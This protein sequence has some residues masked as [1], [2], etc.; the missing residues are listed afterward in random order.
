MEFTLN[1]PT[2]GGTEI[3]PVVKDGEVLFILGANGTGKSSLMHRFFT[4]HKEQ[5]HRIAAHRRNWFSSN[6]VEVSSKQRQELGTNLRNQDMA[7]DSRWKDD[8]GE[9]RTSFAL[10][11]LINS[12]NARARNIAAAVDGK[13][14]LLAEERSAKAAPI[15]DINELLRLSNIHIELTIEE[16]DRVVARK[17]GGNEYSISELSDGER[18]ALL[19]AAS[20]LT[21]APSTLILIDEPERHLHRSIVSP[22]LSLLVAKRAD[23][24]F[25]VSTHEVALPADSRSAQSVLLRACTFKDKRP[26]TWEA[27]L[28]PAGSDLDDALFKALLGSRRR[29]L[30]VE[31][32][33]RSLDKPLYSLVFPDISVIPKSS[34]RDVEHTVIAMR[35]ANDCH[36]VHAFGIIDLDQRDADEVEALREKGI[37]PL[38]VHAVES[39]YYHP[40]IQKR[41]VVRH[42]KV[43]GEDWES[44]REGA[45]QAALKAIGDSKTHLA[46]SAAE[47]LARQEVFRQLPNK[48]HIK[49]GLPLSI[50]VDIPKA[51]QEELAALDKDLAAGNL[52]VL[53]GRYP[54]RETPALTQLATKL[55]FKDRAQYEGAVL[56]LL[57]DDAE[58][59]EFVRSLF[60]PLLYDMTQV[61]ARVQSAMAT[62]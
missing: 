38:A 48:S 17:E 42:S 46:Q 24:A 20:V 25:V 16:N 13:N 18:N 19:I 55:G 5:A 21:V 14:M 8:L 41:V 62:G 33:E 23:C 39:V 57:V 12:E 10:Y 47:K 43:T 15:K 58:A 49:D 53:I 28:V 50:A 59:L 31:G 32:R 34:C 40:E 35:N 51:L 7:P 22:F 45:Q 29:I 2:T 36:W 26:A 1:I 6:A 60:G 11:D 54:V 61:N 37:Y 4:L 52:S 27:D 30:F 56:K 3:V 9:Y 44:L